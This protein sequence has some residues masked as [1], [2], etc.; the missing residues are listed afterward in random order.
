VARH[1][2]KSRFAFDVA[3]EPPVES[4]RRRQMRA[5]K[6]IGSALIV[7]GVFSVFLWQ[8]MG[9]NWP[10]AIGAG[11]VLGLGIFAVVATRAS[12]TDIAADAAWRTAAPEL[13]PSSDRRATEAAR[14]TTPG[15]EKIRRRGDR[16]AGSSVAS[17]GD[18]GAGSSTKPRN[19]G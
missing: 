18:A 2:L 8:T 16:I 13:P 6:A 11:L 12:E 9:A 4:S 1:R 19:I 15:P 14:N 10:F 5:L 7:G 17:V 3:P